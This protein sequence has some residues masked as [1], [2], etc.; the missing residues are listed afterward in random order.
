MDAATLVL[1]ATRIEHLN[2]DAPA[3][4]RILLQ[5]RS[6]DVMSFRDWC[7]SEFPSY[8]GAY[9]CMGHPRYLELAEWSRVFFAA[10]PER[11]EA[12]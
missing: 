6:L 3:T 2:Y 10:Q 5:A 8:E 4:T 7:L 9:I 11:L 12:L 1:I